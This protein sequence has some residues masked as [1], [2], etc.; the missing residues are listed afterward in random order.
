MRNCNKAQERFSGGR[1]THYPHTL[2]GLA[3][4]AFAVTVPMAQAQGT[5]AFV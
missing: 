1:R 2:L 5:P 3:M 4:A